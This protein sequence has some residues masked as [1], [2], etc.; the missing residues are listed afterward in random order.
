MSDLESSIIIGLF[1]NTAI[2][3]SFTMLYQTVGIRIEQGSQ[4][5]QKALLGLVIGAIGIILMM[6]PWTFLPGIVFDT[7]SVMLVCSGL[8]FGSLPTLVAMGITIAFRLFMGGA[9]MWMGTAV[10]LLSGIVGLIWRH[11]RF[12]WMLEHTLRELVLAGYI[13][14]LLMLACTILLPAISRIETLRTLFIPIFLVYPAATVLLGLLMKRQFTEWQNRHV[15]EDLRESERRFSEILKSSNLVTVLLDAQNRITFCNQYF[16]DITGYNGKELMGSDYYETFIPEDIRQETKVM[17]DRFLSGADG[18]QIHENRIQT[19]EGKELIIRWNDTRLYDRFGKPAG[20]AGVGVNITD[21][22]YYELSLIETNEIIARQNEEY[23]RLN[24]EL[25]MAM[26]KAEESNR[27]K[28]IFLA[29]MSHE[30]RTPMNGILGFADL[31]KESDLT[32]TQQQHYISLIEKS[33]AR[34]LG[35]IND[36]VDISKIESGQMEINYGPVNVNYILQDLYQFFLP[37]ATKKGLILKMNSLV[38]PDHALIWSDRE[39]IYAV[40]TNLVKNA[41]KYSDKGSILI[42]CEERQEGLL[43]F[44]QDEG[45]GIA[46]NDLLK[47][48]DRFY[49]SD[50]HG[51]SKFEGAG[52]G[53]SISSA[54]VEMLGGKIEVSSV[55]GAGSVFS[56]T[57]PLSLS[58]KPAE[59]Q[60]DEYSQKEPV[61]TI[62]GLK[63]LI[64]EDDEMIDD[65]LYQIIRKYCSRVYHACNG[66]EAV[67][68]ARAHPELDIIL[69]DIRMPELDGLEAASTI[70]EFNKD[71]I[72]IAQTA[73]ALTGDRERALEK[74]FNDYIS[75]P[76]KADELLDL[77]NHLIHQRDN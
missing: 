11:Y 49:Q 35:I 25:K 73:F 76:I 38:L 29:N 58:E 13:A 70:R 28:S 48:F 60:G 15:R 59:V 7:R 50:V 69:M 52:L 14:H 68:L 6:T 27:L 31:L 33:G 37:E 17:I 23:R 24:E 19:R 61:N 4:T 71:V 54:Y 21:Q 10:I 9:G 16:L 42:K 26:H 77:M 36:L 5:R 66:I 34:L 12:R 45:I 20:I 56:F 18:P 67:D 43:F 32:G 41:I 44:V 47:I 75:K 72:I 39:K 57:L 46:E 30:I 63:V 2:L 1:Q 65:Y 8:F 3:L 64:A 40:L 74:D 22:K 53:L 51:Y 62:Q 55:K